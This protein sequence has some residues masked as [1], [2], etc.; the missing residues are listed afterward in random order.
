MFLDVGFL[1]K[2]LSITDTPFMCIGFELF[3]SLILE[4]VICLC[5][6][7]FLLIK[8]NMKYFKDDFIALI[9]IQIETAGFFFQNAVMIT[10]NISA[11]LLNS[12]L[13]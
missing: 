10:A 9:S 1:I 3:G 6:L 12:P 5:F 13:G 4:N 8:L 11:N 7:I 2:S